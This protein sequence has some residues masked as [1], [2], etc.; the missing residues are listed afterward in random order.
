MSPRCRRLPHLLFA[1][2][3]TSAVP[4]VFTAC[5]GTQGN[6]GPTQDIV[7]SVPFKAGEETHYVLQDTHGN[8]KGTGVLSVEPGSDG[9]L[10]LV[11]RYE[12]G[13]NTD[14]ATV[15][16]DAATLKPRTLH[17][18]IHSD[19]SQQVLDGEYRDD[20][21]QI[22]QRTDGNERSNPLRLKANSYDNDSSLFLWRAIT[23]S[24][25]YQ[26]RYN[27]VITNRRQVSAV[28]LKVT[29]R[30][31]VEVPAGTF[32]AWRLEISSGGVTQ[33]AWIADRP[34]RLLVKY[35]NHAQS[36]RLVFLLTQ[37]PS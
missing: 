28:T 8:E 33:T 6:S 10:A 36:G 1:V 4:A 29:G 12:S 17:R 30:E 7:S 2:L 18:E 20:V 9:G 19:S 13:P 23:F 3:V 37:V 35:D 27:T 15:T 32:D 11:L 16:V 34:D 26:A 22:T 25:G 5:A 24:D 21:V 14:E 31:S